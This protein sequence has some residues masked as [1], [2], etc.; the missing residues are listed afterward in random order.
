[1]VEFTGFLN[2][3]FRV[4][5][6]AGEN[7]VCLFNFIFCSFERCVVMYVLQLFGVVVGKMSS[8]V[9]FL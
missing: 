3:K 4:K 6:V 9:L 2:N 7:L 5:A 8:P 1:M